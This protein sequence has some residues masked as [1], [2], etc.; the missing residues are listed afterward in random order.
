MTHGELTK[1]AWRKANTS[2]QLSA[3]VANVSAVASSDL[4]I[5]FVF[6]YYAFTLTSLY[7]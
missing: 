2:L 5:F 7:L 6:L 4:P 1:T 3:M